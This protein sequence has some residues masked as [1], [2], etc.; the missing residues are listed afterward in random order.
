MQQAQQKKL[1]ID[2]ADLNWTQ[3]KQDRQWLYGHTAIE[4]ITL[5]QFINDLWNDQ[6]GMFW[7]MIRDQKA[8]LKEFND[9]P[10]KQLFEFLDVI[11]DRAMD[12]EQFLPEEIYGYHKDSHQVDKKPNHLKLVVSNYFRPLDRI[13]QPPKPE[14]VLTLV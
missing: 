1:A 12:T 4:A 6:F 2:L 9:Q 14:P 10:A 3:L 7:G 8:W 13:D 11:Q 5:S